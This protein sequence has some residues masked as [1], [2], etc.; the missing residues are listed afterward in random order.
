MPSP[1]WFFPHSHDPRTTLG[2]SYEKQS[3]EKDAQGWFTM[4]NIISKLHSLASTNIILLFI[5]KEHYFMLG[6]NLLVN[7]V[8]SL[9]SIKKKVF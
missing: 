5:G 6:F 4:P 8:R 7:Y 2:S 3:G 1:A 9:E